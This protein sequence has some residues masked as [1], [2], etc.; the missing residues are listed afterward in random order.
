MPFVACTKVSTQA[1]RKPNL[2]LSANAVK[3]EVLMEI[4]VLWDG[5]PYGFVYRGMK[6]F[7]NVGNY[8]ET[9]VESSQ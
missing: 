8:L 1:E 3:S 6:P 9:V 2:I 4:Q 5:T 7:R